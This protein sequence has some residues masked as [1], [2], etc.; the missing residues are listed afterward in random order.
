MCYETAEDDVLGGQHIHCV[1]IA[2][3]DAERNGSQ[4]TIGLHRLCHGRDGEG[5][6]TTAGDRRRLALLYGCGDDGY[7]I[8]CS[9]G[10][11]TLFRE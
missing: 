9:S 2:G 8:F 11:W 4:P 10:V 3:F 7:L 6:S 1:E 5:A